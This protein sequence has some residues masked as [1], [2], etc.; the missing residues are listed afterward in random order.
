MLSLCPL[1]VT[2]HLPFFASHNRMVPSTEAEAICWLSGDHTTLLTSPVCPRKI[3]IDLPALTSHI[4]MALSLEGEAIREPFGDH[5]I[6]PIGPVCKRRT[7]RRVMPGTG[8]PPISRKS[9]GSG[10]GCWDVGDMGVGFSL[11]SL[12][13]RPC[14]VEITTGHIVTARFHRYR[15]E[16]VRK[17]VS[18]SI[19][20]G[21]QPRVLQPTADFT[22]NIAHGNN[23]R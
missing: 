4:K 20:I 2:R 10:F 21:R 11:N 16:P 8:E 15:P 5:A 17:L 1:R 7:L 6:R 13:L 18:R 3:W 23:S 14:A 9:L 12:N 19:L 22:I